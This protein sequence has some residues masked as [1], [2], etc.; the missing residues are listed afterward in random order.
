MV[1]GDPLS[2]PHCRRGDLR[3]RLH[4]RNAA[5]H[6]RH[7]RRGR[8]PRTERL[9]GAGDPGGIGGGNRCRTGVPHRPRL[10]QHRRA[11]RFR[12]TQ[13]QGRA[14]GLLDLRMHQLHP[15]HP[16]SQAPGG[17]VP[18]R[19]GGDR[20]ALSEVRQRVADREHSR[21]RPALRP[22]AS[23]GQRREL[24]DLG[25]VAGDGMANDRAGRPCGKRRWHPRR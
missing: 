19:V 6:R 13:G 22:G 25:G 8:H 3:Q 15:H 10:A 17:R 21:G 9:L 18:E 5:R 20:G 2:R 23:R 7:G 1:P 16:R 4:R 12:G 24:R 14:P 11:A